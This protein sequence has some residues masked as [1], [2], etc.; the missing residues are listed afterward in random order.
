MSRILD[1]K[2]NSA[3]LRVTFVVTILLVLVGA[4]VA[5]AAKNGE[6]TY[7]WSALP[8]GGTVPVVDGAYSEWDTTNVPAFVTGLPGDSNGSSDFVS[9]L[10]NASD[11]TKPNAVVL[12]RLFMRYDCSTNIAYFLVL[13]E[14]NTDG[15]DTSGNQMV[16]EGTTVILDK[17]TASTATN[18]QFAY[19][20][21]AG[22]TNPLGWEGSVPLT[23]GEHTLWVHAQ[24]W[25]NGNTATAGS[26]GKSYLLSLSCPT[27]QAVQVAAFT[28][29][30]A[31]GQVT[32]NW[33]TVSES[34]NLGFNVYRS[35]SANG[36]WNQLNADIVPSAAPGSS[37]GASYQYVDTTVAGGQEYFYRI[38]AVDVYGGTEE[39]GMTSISVDDPGFGGSG[40]VFYF[41]FMKR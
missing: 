28:A 3:A 25:Y 22:M 18:D 19:V 29:D 1:S 15:L 14:S 20:Y 9:D 38:E 30:A 13:S 12:S 6:P 10:W 37:D 21:Q 41:P 31:R 24:V 16:K 40:K 2:R 27:P 39:V 33:E 36:P 11:S 35:S 23:E 17:N 34:H 8:N 4:T 7:V 5:D 26:D 32:L